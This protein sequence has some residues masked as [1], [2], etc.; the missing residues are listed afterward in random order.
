MKFV[1]NKDKLTIEDKDKPNSGSVQ[2]YEVEV[3]YDESWEGLTIKAVLVE[4]DA[5]KGKSIALINNK[6]YIDNELDGTYEIGFVGYTIE[7]D[8]KV[9]QISTNLKSITFNKGAGQIETQEGTL[10]T[11]SEWEIY[12]AQI[13]DM[14]DNIDA[15]PAG[16]TTGQ[17]L[18]KKSNADGDV[19]WQTVQSGGGAEEDNITI[20]KNSQQ[21]IQA[22]AIKDTNTGNPDKFWTG[23]QQE[24]EAIT[25]KDPNTFYYITD[26][27]TVLLSDVQVNGTTVVSDGVA[28]IVTKTAY[29]ASSN[30]IATE[31]DLPDI[32][33]KQD[34][35]DSFHKLSSD[36]VDDTNNT[37]KFVTASEKT[38]W[39]NKSDFSGN[40]NDLSN[41]PTI[42]DELKDLADDTTHRL[43]TDTEKSTWNGKSVVSGTN[44][45]TNWSTITI[46]GTTKNIPSGGGGGGTATDVQI[47]GTSIVSN[48]TAN[49]ITNTAYNSSSNKIATMSDLPDISGKQDK[50]LVE[51]SAQTTITIDPNKYYT[52]GEV[53]SLNITLTTPSDNT[54]YN[55]YMFEFD[56]GTTP[57]SLILPN[58]V[59]WVETPTI[60]ASKTYQVSIVNNI[61][62]IVGV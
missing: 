22:V 41:K 4:A 37:N 3:E 26:D 53:A 31:S 27:D 44:D 24:Y 7:N 2:Y 29:N 19:E 58:T 38:T 10:P 59:S 6:I 8:T 25:T 36:L 18:A 16:G 35:I 12:V 21:K 34:E 52:F 33:G 47:N 54:I 32:S 13:Q 30:K 5:D 20:T 14:I 43:V 40:Y 23:T 46:D 61:A 60:E 28:N 50:I 9:Y 39:N 49:I 62:L 42:P 17:V 11:P 45:G 51:T 55:E 15:I 57:T 48:N 1:L 56:S